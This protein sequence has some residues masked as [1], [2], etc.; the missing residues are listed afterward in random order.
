MSQVAKSI[1]TYVA[2]DVDSEEGAGSARGIEG[3]VF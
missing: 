2:W 1:R 3:V